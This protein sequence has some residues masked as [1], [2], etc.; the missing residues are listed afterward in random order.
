MSDPKKPKTFFDDIME[1]VKTHD[2][3]RLDIKAEIAQIWTA[4]DSARVT[5]WLAAAMSAIALV[6]SVIAIIIVKLKT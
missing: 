1:D 5:A 4:V 3:S 2:I 6:F